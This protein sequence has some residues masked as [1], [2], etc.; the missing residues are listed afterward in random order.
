MKKFIW[1]AI[2][3]L[4]MVSVVY[5][6]DFVVTDAEYIVIQGQVSDSLGWAYGP[7]DSVRITVTDSAG[8]ELSDAWY[9]SLDAQATLNGDML[10]FFDQWGDINGSASIGVFSLTATFAETDGSSNKLYRQL[11]FSVRGVDYGVNDAHNSMKYLSYY[12]GVGADPGNYISLR[13]FGSYNKDTLYFRDSGD[14]TLFRIVYVRTVP[15]GPVD[16]IL[17]LEP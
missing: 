1:L 7:P 8:T 3:L 12:W 13:P 9:N 4:I 11:V 6:E 2:M 10:V 16:S 17:F 5:A 15:G 14:N